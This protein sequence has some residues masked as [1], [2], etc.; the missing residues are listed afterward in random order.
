MG[1]LDIV[2]SLTEQRGNGDTAAVGSGLIQE[3]ENAPG[4]IS[5]IFQAFQ[6]NGLGGLVQQ[7]ST[8]ESQHA[9][10]DQI[11]QGLG[12][13]GVIE[14]I[15]ERTGLP[16]NVIEIGLAALIPLVIHHF[17]TNGH[18]DQDGTPTGIPVPDS[19]SLLQSILGKLL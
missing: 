18:T 4:G 13:T 16:P 10:P 9:T 6:Q 17:V 1:I 15:S 12:N 14:K 11:Q 5:G 19:G 3:L 8:G 7:W 2:S